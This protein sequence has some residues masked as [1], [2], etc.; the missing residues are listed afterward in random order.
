MDRAQMC[1]GPGAF[2]KMFA[3]QVAVADNDGQFVNQITYQRPRMLMT[4]L[5]CLPH[6]NNTTF[7]PLM[8]Q[9]MYLRF[10]CCEQSAVAMRLRASH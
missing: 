2:H 9:G 3:Q 10:I 6:T 8:I 7:S 4:Y 1:G 5:T